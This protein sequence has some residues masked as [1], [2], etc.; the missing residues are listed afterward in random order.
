MRLFVLSRASCTRMARAVGP[1]ME[2]E[3]GGD[4]EQRP[5]DNNGVDHTEH[6]Y[7]PSGDEVPD[8]AC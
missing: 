6:W 4:N 7:R 2:R 5:S 8:H 1:R 3:Y